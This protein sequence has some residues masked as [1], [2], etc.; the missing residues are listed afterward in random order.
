MG[1]YDC[2]VDCL[3]FKVLNVIGTLDIG[4]QPCGLPEAGKTLL[5]LLGKQENLTRP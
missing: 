2:I 5:L 1:V 3:V 4:D